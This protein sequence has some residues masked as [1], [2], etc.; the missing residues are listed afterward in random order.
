MT[1]PPLPFAW[2]PPALLGLACASC[3]PPAGAVAHEAA[4]PAAATS[5]PPPADPFA[6]DE[7]RV[8]APV[9]AP[10]IPLALRTLIRG[11]TVLT[12]TGARYDPG[13]VLLEGGAIAAVGE[14][15]GPAP[16]ESTVVV[17][18]RGKFVTPGIIDPHSHLGVYPVPRTVAHDDGNELTDPV[19]AGVR[20]EDSFWPQDP[21]IERAVA[22]GVTTIGVLPGSGN[23]IGGRGVVLHLAPQRGAR[24]MRFSG[25]PEIVKLACGENPKRAYG[26]K[27]RAPST[28]MGNLRG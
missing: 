6:A 5:P 10:A 27:G 19:T 24:A 13:F 17:D 21:S 4:T 25:A 8:R 12:A 15:A 22:G 20:A 16:D 7:A 3:E 9:E 18:G 11:A 2:A 1:R 23:L 26:E 14:G 28:R